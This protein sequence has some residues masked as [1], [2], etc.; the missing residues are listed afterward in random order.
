MEQ[1]RRRSTRNRGTRPFIGVDD[2]D[3]EINNGQ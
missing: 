1:G 3:E 2:I